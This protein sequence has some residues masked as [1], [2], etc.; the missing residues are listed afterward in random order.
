MLLDLR[1][2]LEEHHVED[3]EMQDLASALGKFHDDTVEAPKGKR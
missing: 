1:T 3:N 2:A